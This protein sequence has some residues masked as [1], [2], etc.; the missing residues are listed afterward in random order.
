[1]VRNMRPFSDREVRRAVSAMQTGAPLREVL[2]AAGVSTAEIAELRRAMLE[3]YPQLA[4]F[5]LPAKKV[6]R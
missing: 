2:D 3:R 5:G 6:E 1:M 4:A